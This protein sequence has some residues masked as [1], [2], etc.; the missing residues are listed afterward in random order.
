MTNDMLGIKFTHDM[1]HLTTGIIMAGNIEAYPI[2]GVLT[3]V[4]WGL[5]NSPWVSITIGVRLWTCYYREKAA[6]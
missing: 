5:E 1:T 4:V 3:L 2:S 6:F